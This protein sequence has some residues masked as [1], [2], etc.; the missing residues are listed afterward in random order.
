[1]KF[2]VFKQIKYETSPLIFISPATVL[3]I[4]GTTLVHSIL[5]GDDENVPGLHNFGFPEFG[6]Q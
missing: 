1:M 4:P 6:G 3:Y 2:V 5:P